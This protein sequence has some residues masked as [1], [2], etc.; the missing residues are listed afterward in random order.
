MVHPPLNVIAAYE[1]QS[2][3]QIRTGLRLVGRNDGAKAGLPRCARN[4]G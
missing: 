4:D 1:P 3:L 2:I